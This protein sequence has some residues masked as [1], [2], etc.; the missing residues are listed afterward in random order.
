MRPPLTSAS[1][2]TQ[3]LSADFGAWQ[4]SGR[5]V[6]NSDGAELFLRAQTQLPPYT[7]QALQAA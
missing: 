7:S 4:P 5:V 6:A 3:A 1:R 2:P